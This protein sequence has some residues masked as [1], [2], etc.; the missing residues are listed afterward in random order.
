MD[1]PQGRPYFFFAGRLERFKGLDD[2]IP[3][4]H[5]LP[6]VDLVIAGTGDHAETLRRIAAGLPNVVFLGRLPVESL[7][8]WYRH[9]MATVIPSNCFETF[10]AVIIEALREGS[11]VVARR[12]GPFPELLEGTGAG[13]L[14]STAAEL[15]PILR[16]VLGDPA[17]RDRMVTNA[18]RVFRE[19]WT[20]DVV[21][22][23]YLELILEAASRRGMRHL[24][25]ESDRRPPVPG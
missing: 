23:R 5:Q 2:V 3:A 12:V 8:R 14:F 20:E 6:E 13:A 7:A 16:R 24:L 17:H 15:V 11:P 1:R 4:F 21:V 10:G 9:A 22:P 18:H 25:G 19:R